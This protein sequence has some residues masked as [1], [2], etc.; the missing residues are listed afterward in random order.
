MEKLIHGTIEL[1]ALK[2]GHASDLWG[3]LLCAGYTVETSIKK[4]KTDRVTQNG[5]EDKIVFKIMTEVQ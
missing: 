5:T 2:M 1:D 4:T 3:I